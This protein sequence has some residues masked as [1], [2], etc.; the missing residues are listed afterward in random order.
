MFCNAI[1][2]H[3]YPFDICPPISIVSEGRFR[4][5]NG[6]VWIVVYEW[7]ILVLV[8]PAELSLPNSPI[9]WLTILK[10]LLN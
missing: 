1:K 5:W 2:H 8:L 9:Q 6:Y 10:R 7:G 3:S 4:N